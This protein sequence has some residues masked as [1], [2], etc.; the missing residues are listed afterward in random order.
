MHTTQLGRFKILSRLSVGGMA[1]I[2]LAAGPDPLGERRLVIVKRILP[3]LREREEFIHMF[4]DEAR[5]SASLAHPN[6]AQVYELGREGDELFIA[7]EFV[8][9][10]S[11]SSIVRRCKRL[12]RPLPLGFVALV[13]RHLCQA[14]DSAHNFVQGDGERS[15]IIHRDVSPTNVMVTYDGQVKVIDF[16]V[17]KA[18]GSLSR[19]A[20]GNI[21]GSR[22]YMSPE[23]AR[24][25]PLDA[26]SDIFSAG[27]VLHEL[28]TGKLLFLKDSELLT[29]RGILRDEIPSPLS[30]NPGVP[31]ALSDAVMTALQRNVDLRFKSAADMARAISVAVPA[32]MYTREQAGA[33]MK[34]LFADE[35][36]ETDRLIGM[37][38]G[39]PEAQDRVSKLLEL[40]VARG[41]ST[42]VYG[43]VPTG[44]L[45]LEDVSSDVSD[46]SLGIREAVEAE[47]PVEGATVLSVDDSE[48]S[49]DF[50]EAHLEGAGF[51]VL[52]VGTAQEALAM[53]V[54][55]TPDLV[56]LDVVM[57]GLNGFDLCRLLR[58]RTTRRPFLPILFLSSSDTFEQRLEATAAGA[59]GFITKPYEPQALVAIV[60]AHL[61]RAAFLERAR[62]DGLKAAR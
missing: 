59:D 31:R 25:A 10:Q 11:L 29:F 46:G 44:V 40:G 58:Q 27:I 9:G 45:K 62:L 49:R 55:R 61:K 51:P 13:G 28:L 38:A 8:A 52:A 17:A 60:R 36:R 54:E 7:M 30:G 53:L 41:S 12:K 18:T 56:L 47:P 33:L 14:L 19:T 5:I 16:G 37:H 34:E 1:E 35:Q 24:G 23:Q 48:I 50:I 57:P 2:F 3:D 21:K 15:P 6:I 43:A 22:G 39:D 42:A 20:T 4:L 26:R 32:L